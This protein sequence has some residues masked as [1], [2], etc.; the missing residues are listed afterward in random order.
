VVYWFDAYSKTVLFFIFASLVL[1]VPIAAAEAQPRHGGEVSKMSFDEED[2]VSIV[3]ELEESL[4]D[5][6]GEGQ[7]QR[8]GQWEKKKEP[9]QW[10]GGEKREQVGKAT[11]TSQ[12][13]LMKG[14]ATALGI[15]VG[16]NPAPVYEAYE[17]EDYSQSFYPPNDSTAQLNQS[18]VSFRSKLSSRSKH[19]SG[20]EEDQY[21]KSRLNLSELLLPSGQPHHLKKRISVGSTM[22]IAEIGKMNF[23]TVLSHK[24][25]PMIHQRRKVQFKSKISE[26]KDHLQGVKRNLRPLPSLL[27]LHQQ[28]SQ[29]LPHH[30]SQY[31]HQYQQPYSHQ[32]RSKLFKLNFHYKRLVKKLS[33][34]EIN[35]ESHSELEDLRLLTRRREHNHDVNHTSKK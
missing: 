29:S 22:R 4:E 32:S 1:L 25:G 27:L 16:M 18:M 26:H 20:D 30:L 12:S 7:E 6:E 14:T 28:H 35:R 34:Y 15:G 9:A 31:L 3:S 11:A 17:E 10:G 21:G 19:K 8:Q 2:E 33:L 24:R 5:D 23:L 13:N